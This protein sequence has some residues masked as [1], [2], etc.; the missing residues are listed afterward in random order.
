MSANSPAR[1]RAGGTKAKMINRRIM[2]K[3]GGWGGASD[4]TV[5]AGAQVIAFLGFGVIGVDA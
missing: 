1:I 5:R 2:G 3:I 4:L